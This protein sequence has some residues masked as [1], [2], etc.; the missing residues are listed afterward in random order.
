MFDFESICVEE[1]SSKDAVTTNWIGKQYPLLVSISSNYVKEPFS[2]CNS[3]ALQLVA[4]FIGAH[5]NLRFRKKIIKK[6]SLLQIEAKI[7]FKRWSILEKFSLR[8]NCRE[9]AS[10]NDL[11]N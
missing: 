11:Q 6:S 9:Q 10:H 3:D 5:E 8:Q 1:R 7:L 2:F 4:T